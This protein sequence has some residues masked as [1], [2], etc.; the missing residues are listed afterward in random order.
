MKSIV[1][2][3]LVACSCL[4]LADDKPGHSSHGTAFDSGMRTKPWVIPGVGNAPFAITTKHGEV[5][6]WFD[7]GNALLH[8]FWFEEAERTFRWCLKLDPD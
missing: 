5:Q 7:Q 3:L 4:G 2:A 1:L 8:S 6:K